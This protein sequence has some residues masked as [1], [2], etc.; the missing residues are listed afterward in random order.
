LNVRDVMTGAD[1]VVTVSPETT[2]KQVAELM[3]EHR[4]SG[5]PVVDEERHVLGVVSE[6]DIV[7]GE[8]GGT[9]THGMI[10][11]ARAVGDPAAVAISRT[12]GEAMSSPPVTIG[13][14]EAVARATHLIAERGVNRLPVV[15]EEGRLV[16]IIARADVVRA[17]ARPDEEI[18]SGVRDEIERFLGFGPDAVQ[19]TVADGEVALSGEVDTGANVRLAAFFA[20][21]FPGV[22]AVRSEL[23]AREDGD[24]LVDDGPPTT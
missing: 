2:L 11:R 23:R 24:R 7:S 20:S 6:G 15:D 1:R 16:G 18:E 13:P 12:A 14:D 21:L 17:F 10:A 19:V 9:G 22:V 3:L 8:T 4:I 5:L